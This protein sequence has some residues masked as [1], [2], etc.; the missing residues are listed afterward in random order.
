MNQTSKLM[1]T[2]T[3]G[4]AIGAAASAA[5]MLQQGA[6]KAAYVIADVEVTDPAGFL[7]YVAKVPDTLKAFNGRTMARGKPDTK[8]GEAPKGSIVIIAF[9][10]LEDADKWYSSPQYTALIPERQKA[11]RSQ[12]YIVEGVP[13]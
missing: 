11:A 10:T 7:A 9:D 13:Q 1:I 12:V 2:L 8:E 5:N 4:M 3:V 6:K